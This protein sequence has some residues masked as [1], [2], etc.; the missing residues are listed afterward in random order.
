MSALLKSRARVTAPLAVGLT[1]L[2]GISG[3][4][5]MGASLPGSGSLETA[6]RI[7]IAT[8]V[9]VGISS[10]VHL[11]KV[12]GRSRGR[13]ASEGKRLYA[14]IRYQTGDNPSATGEEPSELDDSTHTEDASGRP[15]DDAGGPGGTLS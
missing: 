6:S 12:R 3:M 11:T 8:A 9:L 13:E 14:A 15:G 10:T 5:L 2:E 4:V 1:V 7:G